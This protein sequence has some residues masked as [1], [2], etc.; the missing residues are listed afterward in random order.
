[1]YNGRLLLTILGKR[2]NI[3]FCETHFFTTRYRVVSVVLLVQSSCL[4]ALSFSDLSLQS[5][6]AIGGI[7]P[8]RT[9]L[10]RP[11]PFFSPLTKHGIPRLFSRFGHPGC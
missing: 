10:P 7:H 2:M 11:T 9:P 4:P 5:H 6:R 8:I 3:T 1:M